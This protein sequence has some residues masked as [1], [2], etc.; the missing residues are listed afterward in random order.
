MAAII[1]IN[2]CS[3]WKGFNPANNRLLTL[4]KQRF[5]VIVD[6]HPDVLIHSVFG[7]DFLKYQ[8]MRVCF[9]GENTRPNFEESPYQIGFDWNDH[10][11]YLRWPLFLFTAPIPQLLEE[12]NI[13]DT[14]AQHRK[15]A[16]FLVSNADAGERIEF[17][18][19]LSMFKRVDSGGRLLNN[20]GYRVDNIHSFLGQYKFTI[21]FENSS[22]PGY[23][24]EKMTQ[25][26]LARS[27]PIYWGNPRVGA[28]FNSKSFINVHNYPSFDAAIEYIKE[29]D[30]DLALYKGMLAQPWFK[31]NQ[32][33]DAF[34]QDR[35]FD[36]FDKIFAD[37]H[38]TPTH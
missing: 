19:K 12:K 11:N 33:P 28:D 32:L 18:R 31:N 27:I 17:Y 23:T 26:M 21:A 16:A 20:L 5:N 3:F 13:S 22:H 8:G 25:A 37:V 14:I 29:V 34:K 38:K 2:F 10:P 1:K 15:F 6:K 24:T 7:R 30:R 36:F 9:T 4:L 35:F